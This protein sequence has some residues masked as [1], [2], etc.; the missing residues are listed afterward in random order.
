MS[1]LSITTIQTALH[2]ENK[3]AN[4]SMLEEKILGIKEPTQVVVLPEMFSTGFSMK[5]E[6]LAEGMDGAT[7]Q[8]MKELAARKRVILT[9]SIIVQ[10]GD[11]FYN[12]MIWMLPNGETFFYDKRHLFGYGEED[13]H[14]TPG[15][16]RSI[17]S[18]NGWKICLNICYDLRFPVWMRQQSGEGNEYDVLLC[19]ANWPDRRSAAWKIL[20]Q[21]RAI[22]NQ[23]YAVGVNRVGKDGNGLY[24][25]GDSMV[26]DPLGAVLYHKADE[27]DVFT[28][29][30]EKAPLEATRSK[31]P[32]WKEK[33][34][35][36]I[37]VSA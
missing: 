10:D 12:R 33:D 1:D 17:V 4:L 28:I 31:L 30:L 5:P 19:V 14:Y 18:V 36:D 9:G 23:A 6:V 32:F 29:V 37:F 15:E 21:A 25:S 3:P 16:K 22:E 11:R 2:W 26:V 8:W 34:K 27:E 35:F 7:V 13:A 24:H 20:L